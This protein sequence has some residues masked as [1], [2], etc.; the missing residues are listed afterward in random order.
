MRIAARPNP[1][2]LVAGL[3]AA[4]TVAGAAHATTPASAVVQSSVSLDASAQRV[5]TG[6]PVTFTARLTGPLGAIGREP[7]DFFSRAGSG[8]WRQV[9][10]VRTDDGGVAK[11]TRRLTAT[12]QWQVR[13]AGNVVVD[14]ASSPTR[15]VTVWKPKPRPK[16][17]SVGFGERVIREAARHEGAPYQYGAAGPDRFDCSGFTM[18]VFAKFGVRL[19]HNA[20]AQYDAVRHVPASA[21]QLGDLVF[22]DNGGG[23]SHVGIYAGHGQ[24][25]AATHSGDTV[26][27]QSIYS[28]YV[29]G[30]AGPR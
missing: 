24:M 10:S 5:R 30:R 29:V 8:A 9:A 11:L 26:R 19:P 28:S 1:A 7:L 22:I 20:A 14:G 17:A 4:V 25:W 15:T 2:H 16:P 18:Y 3:V 23:I 21:M 13:W 12:A 6:T 27:L